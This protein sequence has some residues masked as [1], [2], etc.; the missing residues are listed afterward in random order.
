MFRF[1]PVIVRMGPVYHSSGHSFSALPPMDVVGSSHCLIAAR[2]AFGPRG[3]SGIPTPGRG[4]G[5]PVVA[6]RLPPRSAIGATG[7]DDA[8]GLGDSA[9]ASGSGRTLGAGNGPVSLAVE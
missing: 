4:A 7:V 9:T 1:T 2:R 5:F 8:R 6:L 3:R